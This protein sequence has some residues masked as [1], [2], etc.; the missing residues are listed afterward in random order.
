MSKKVKDSHTVMTQLILPNDTNHLGNLMGGVMMRWMDIVCALSGMRHCNG[1]VVTAAVDHISFNEP[2][3]LGSMITLECFVT[4]AF[5]TSLEVYVEVF[6]ESFS[7]VKTKC[8]E[9]FFTFVAL[10]EETKKPVKVP[11]V[12]PESERELQLYES[13]LRRRELRLIMSG[14]IDPKDADSLKMLFS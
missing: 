8:N 2:I 11:A 5:K 14:R 9:A 7:G 13:A 1:P 6:S 3:A 4:R 10:D 12:I